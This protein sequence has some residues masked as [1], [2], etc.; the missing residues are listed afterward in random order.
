MF[1]LGQ[2]WR[3]IISNVEI[4]WYQGMYFKKSWVVSHS[5]YFRLLQFQEKI[6]TLH[7][8]EFNHS[9]PPNTDK[10]TWVEYILWSNYS[11]NQNISTFRMNSTQNVY[12]FRKKAEKR[13]V[14]G[15]KENIFRSHSIL[16][17]KL[18]VC[19]TVIW[20]HGELMKHIGILSYSLSTYIHTHTLT[21]EKH[22][23]TLSFPHLLCHR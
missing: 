7:K 4:L 11:L 3:I 15:L 16:S 17:L 22:S 20:I 13:P 21:E 19:S 8:F 9:K 1:F 23:I 14:D 10:N 2:L 6:G 5:F 12:K 18:F